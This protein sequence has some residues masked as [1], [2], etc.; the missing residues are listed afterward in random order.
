VNLTRWGDPPLIRIL[1]IKEE[2]TIDQSFPAFIDVQQTF[3][4]YKFEKKFNNLVDR[5]LSGETS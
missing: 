1:S 5:K 4:Y 2:K 3:S